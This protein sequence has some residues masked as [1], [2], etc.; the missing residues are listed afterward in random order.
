MHTLG[1]PIL[2]QHS[3]PWFSKTCRGIDSGAC[4]CSCTICDDGLIV[5][6]FMAGELIVVVSFRVASFVVGEF[7]QVSFGVV[8]CYRSILVD[9]AGL[10]GGLIVALFR[11]L[12]VG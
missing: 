11:L 8:P 4:F 1:S 6:S 7:I 10:V 12:V 2:Y 9:D 3:I 5:V